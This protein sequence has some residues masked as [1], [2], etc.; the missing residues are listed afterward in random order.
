MNCKSSF[1]FP[2]LHNR[3][4][5]ASVSWRGLGGFKGL[6]L[7]TIGVCKLEK[8][9]GFTCFSPP[10]SPGLCYPHFFFYLLI[11]LDS[12]NGSPLASGRHTG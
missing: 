10:P 4:D 6:L 2:D 8:F 12:D 3:A 5:Q 11:V 7:K 9:L 1:S